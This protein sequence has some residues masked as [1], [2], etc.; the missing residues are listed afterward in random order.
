MRTL[1]VV[2]MSLVV[3]AALASCADRGRPGPRSGPG[4]ARAL[5][6]AALY[7]P[8]GQPLNGGTLGQP[9]CE[10][11][12]NDWFDRA[13]T[14]HD[15]RLDRGEFLANARAQFARMDLDHQGELTPETLSRYRTPFREGT[16]ASG[17]DPVMVADRNLDFK[18][19]EAEFLARAAEVFDQLD[20]DRNGV[21]ERGELPT[22]CA[23]HARSND[24]NRPPQREPGRRGGV[25]S[26][27]VQ[28]P[29][30]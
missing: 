18:V 9:S 24:A 3:M 27:G 1:E 26:L 23:A 4:D 11:A 28:E 25:R 6:V 5:G 20:S 14:G 7:S 29:R 22:L 2:G 12:I 8:N 10:R 17:N 16:R 15:G 21:I 30:P 19:T 13:D